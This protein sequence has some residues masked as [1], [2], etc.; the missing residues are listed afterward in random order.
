[1]VSASESTP[2][3]LLNSVME[4]AAL[5]NYKNT[6]DKLLEE[7]NDEGKLNTNIICKCVI[8]ASTYTT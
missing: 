4:R 6:Y 8:N 7:D 2:T 1:M 5:I 3:K